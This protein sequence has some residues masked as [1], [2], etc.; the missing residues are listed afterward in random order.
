MK[1]EKGMRAT[2]ES[3]IAL[4]IVIEEDEG[5]YAAYCRDLGT[6]SCGKPCR[7]ALENIKDA[8]G[9]HVETLV[10]L[11]EFEGFLKARGVKWT[12]YVAESEHQSSFRRRIHPGALTTVLETPVPAFA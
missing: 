3:F 12:P 2:V 5:Q 10:E 4:T 7:E 1:G 6:A 11:G 9:L 8:V